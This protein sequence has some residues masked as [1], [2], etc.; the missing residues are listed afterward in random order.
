MDELDDLKNIEESSKNIENIDFSN[1]YNVR[2]GGFG[3]SSKLKTYFSSIKVK[4]LKEDLDLYETLTKD[5]TWPISQ[6]VQ[7]EVDRIRVSNISKSYILSEGRPIKYFPPIIVAILPKNKDGS[8]SIDLEYGEDEN[9]E[10]IKEAV[11]INSNFSGNDRIKPYIISSNNLSLTKGLFLLEVSKVFESYLLSWDKSRYYAIV[12]DGQHRLEA[13]YKS[14]DE[15]NN[16]EDYQQDVVFLDFS[17]LLEDEKD[18]SPVEAVRRVFV[19]IN[20]NAQRVG[21]VRQV[22]MDDKDLS[23]LCVQSLVDS[24]NKDGSSKNQ[25]SYLK[26]QIVDWYGDKLKHTLPHLTGI[27]SLYQIINDYLVQENISSINDLRNPKKI[28]KWVTRMNDIFFVDKTIEQNEI[29]KFEHIKSLYDSYQE[30]ETKRQQ[31]SEY[32]SDVEDEYKESELFFY[33]YTVLD[34]ARYNFEKIYLRPIIKFFNNLYPNSETLN[35]I[36]QEGGFN[37]DKNLAKALVSS[38]KKIAITNIYK[39][40]LAKLKNTIEDKLIDDFFL[41]FTVLGQKSTFSILF[42]SI[43]RKINP[44]F[45]EDN[46]MEIVDDKIKEFNNLFN[47]FTDKDISLLSHKDN[48]EIEDIDASIE[49]LGT[50]SNNFWEG[51]IYENDNIIY[52]TQGVRSLSYILNEFICLNQARIDGENYNFDLNNAPYVKSRTK[53]IISKRFNYTD[54]QISEFANKILESKN[55][56]IK[57]YFED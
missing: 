9:L 52:N 41:F 19:D 56:Y 50:I 28:S 14:S 18:I 25:D 33:D 44:D 51:I 22:L 32:D 31:N 7:R 8:I 3:E 38:R 54:D 11:Y 4:H 53:R 55:H 37:L 16:I 57:N 1:I 2:I 27:L 21:F 20:T 6:I 10:T 46:C 48:I 15:D 23:S 30:Y 43:Q 45:S 24:V 40:E 13:L 47:F 34:I 5:K 26:S 12:I 17:V 36:D 39:T 29:E 49:D 35:L 42:S